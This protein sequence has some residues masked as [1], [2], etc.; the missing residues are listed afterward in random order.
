MVGGVGDRME[1]GTWGNQKRRIGGGGRGKGE[2]GE[3]GGRG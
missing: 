2:R 1:D 3:S